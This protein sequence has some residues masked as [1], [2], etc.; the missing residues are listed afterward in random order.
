MLLLRLKKR[1]LRVRNWFAYL[2]LK[3]CQ[4]FWQ[5]KIVV[6]LPENE[7]HI[8]QVALSD[9]DPAELTQQTLAWLQ[10][11]ESMRYERLFSS[12]IARISAGKM[13]DKNLPQ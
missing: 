1:A 3:L 5:E 2:I 6:N 13:A 11:K 7:I 10:A 8:W 4:A 12:G 9:V